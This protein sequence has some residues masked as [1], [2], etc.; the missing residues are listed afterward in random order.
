MSQR[1]DDFRL[2]FAQFVEPVAESGFPSGFDGGAGEFDFGRGRSSPARDK[3]VP[4]RT[5]S[6]A[7]RRAVKAIETDD[8]SITVDRREFLR[9]A[10]GIA[11]IGAGAGVAGAQQGRYRAPAV[12][13]PAI[14][15]WE[16]EATLTDRI[17]I[18]ARGWTFGDAY[19]TTVIYKDSRLTDALD[20]RLRRNFDGI[21]GAFAPT[22]VTFDSPLSVF[23]QPSLVAGLA[24]RRFERTARRRG[25]SALRERSPAERETSPRRVT[26]EYEAYYDIGYDVAHSLPSVSELPH[27]RPDGRVKTILYF[28]VSRP[29]GSLILT[30]A[31]RPADAMLRDV[32]GRDGDAY[33]AELL[34][35]MHSVR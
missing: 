31:A 4:P 12:T 28:D 23:A 19:S 15:E 32:F 35:L 9:R 13:S 2:P 16:V 29:R 14:Q 1:F 8:D 27:V 7:S 25:F 30:S 3:T 24:K 33:R 20:E 21:V 5:E 18:R 34:R 11:A 26:A 6:P 17:P 22:R 10:G